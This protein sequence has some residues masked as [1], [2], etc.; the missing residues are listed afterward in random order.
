MLNHL[1]ITRNLS[2]LVHL[3]P[4]TRTPL[5]LPLRFIPCPLYLPLPTVPPLL[6]LTFLP[7]TPPS[8]PNSSLY[9]YLHVTCVTPLTA[10]LYSSTSIL[11]TRM[12]LSNVIDVGMHSYIPLLI[13]HRLSP[14]LFQ[15][16][17]TRLTWNH[18]NVYPPFFHCFTA[19]S[20]H[21]GVSF[22]LPHALYAPRHKDASLS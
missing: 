3:F 14:R 21:R 10:V 12:P 16:M 15:T 11:P 22:L 20:S 18:M 4:L 8:N 17:C 19:A 1:N 13:I 9:P 6:L 2:L 5:L 7:P